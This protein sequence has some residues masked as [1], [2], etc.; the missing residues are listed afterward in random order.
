LRGWIGGAF[1]LELAQ[2]LAGQDGRA[3]DVVLAALEAGEG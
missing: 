3:L 2:F 1:G